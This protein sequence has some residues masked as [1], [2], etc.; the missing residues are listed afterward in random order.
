VKVVLLGAGGLLGRSLAS[1][2]PVGTSLS[3]FD[4][5]TA[6]ITDFAAIERLLQRES[7]DWV[8]NATAYTD[9]DGAERDRDAAFRVNGTAVG[10][11]ARGCAT[12]GCG[13]VHFSTDYVFAGDREACYPEDAPV[14][15]VNSYGASKEAGESALRLSGARHVIIR[16]QWLFGEGGRSFLSTVARRARDRQAI[17][18]VADEWGCCTYVEDLA[19]T[20]WEILGRASGTLHL[21]N[22]G[23][24][25]RFDV[26]R[27][28]Y[29][30]AG[31]PE[32]VTPARSA[33]VPMVAKRPHS[34]QLCV[35]KVE[36]L[37]G[38]PMAAWTDAVD[39][40]LAS[41]PY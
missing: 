17:R 13:L 27:R 12:L 29:E 25:S 19:R 11:L 21:A 4:R 23:R 41:L 31:V 33:D 7:P 22:R 20:T 6:D 18:V 34:S 16:T 32:L 36:Q 3:A 8:L 38:R 30:A 14:S 9:V 26:A 28:V 2:P 10:A 5:A 15:P 40:Y 24:V 39:R 37:V 35:D 1:S